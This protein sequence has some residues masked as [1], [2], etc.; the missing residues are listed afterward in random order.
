MSIMQF[1]LFFET[2]KSATTLHNFFS[3]HQLK[4][5]LSVAY[6]KLSDTF[7]VNVSTCCIHVTPAKF[8]A[9]TTE[10]NQPLSLY[11]QLLRK[12]SNIEKFFPQP[13]FCKFDL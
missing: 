7:I 8:I 4:L 9:K 10:L 6:R 5:N 1:R 13:L 3:G 11:I 2:Y 12:A